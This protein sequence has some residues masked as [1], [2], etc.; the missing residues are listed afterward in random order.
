MS[1]SPA[2]AAALPPAA[3]RFA[4]FELKPGERQLVAD[5][6][7]V[8]LG[9]RAFDML[10]ALLER[11]QRVV[12]K[13]EL[14]DVVW[15][16][17]VVEENN[18]QVQVLALRKLLGPAA[19]ATVP[20][21]GYRLTL[22]VEVV[23]AA[24]RASPA[25][26]PPLPSPQRTNL[27]A[28]LPPMVG[29]AADLAALRGL[30]R[31]HTLV[32]IVGAGGIGKTRLAQALVAEIAGDF[33][34]GAWLVE[35]ASLADPAL[36]ASAVA[37]VA[38]ITLSAER[39]A[40]EAVVSVLRSQRMLLALDNCEHLLDGVVDLVD[41][42]RRA[43][44]DVRLLVTSQE[45]LKVVDEQVYRLV[46]L[47]VPPAQ[48][49]DAGDYSAVQLF[50]AA[51]K[52]AEPRF[53]LTRRNVGAVAD[54][55][56]HLDG[57]PLALQL[58]AARVPLLGIEGLRARLDERFHV[59]TGGA[60]TVLRR[61]QTLRGALEWSHGLLTA[62]EQAVFRR[63]GVFAGGF[64]LE[65]A[66]EVAAD[67]TV[68]HWQVLEH[69]GALVDK[70]L[71][72]AEGEDLPRYRLLETTRAFALERLGEAGETDEHLRRHAV[73]TRDLV[74]ALAKD[75]WRTTPAAFAA[76]VAEI[77]NVR[78]AV[79][80]AVAAP[81]ERLLAIELNVEAFRVWY[82]SALLAEGLAHC[83]AAR[84]LLDA[85][86]PPLVAAKF[87]LAYA[88]SGQ[89]SPRADCF[90]A[91]QRAARMFGDLGEASLAYDAY[92]TVAAIGARRGAVAE[93]DAAL[94]AA[95][96][97]E[98]PG[99]PSRQR[100][101]V[102]FGRYLWCQMGGRYAQALEYARQQQQLYREDGSVV[103]E[104]FA[105]GN[106]GF[107]LLALGRPE[108]A[109][110]EVRPAFA[111]LEAL[112][113]GAGAGHVIGA[114]AIALAMLGRHDEARARARIAYARLQHE[115]DTLWLLEP[116]ASSAA[117]LGRPADAARIAGFVDARY[118]TTGEVRRAPAR[119]RRAELDALLDAGLA[120][121]ERRELLA[122]GAV[123]SDDE[124]FA[125]ALGNRS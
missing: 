50:V 2:P 48:A 44:P 39:P 52:A 79:A 59:L 90:E 8:K 64:T 82:A 54:V 3:W 73:T 67:A 105:I 28:R 16:K 71:V 74:R 43:A 41:A 36:V 111:R 70:S 99:W 24:A 12:S 45:P 107:A 60:R 88:K 14:M 58:A 86:I 10:V 106:L 95:E 114:E 81:E 51:A 122:A 78:A 29:R 100:A 18:L 17:L 98:D 121:D 103:G 62:E 32:S 27:T 69:L 40:V 38:G 20:G 91:A 89:Y 63:L 57:I 19:I 72:V 102:R 93:T 123:M 115:G 31:E 110:A 47:A 94:A 119:E 1:E 37:R 35:L 84:P 53:A 80:W 49:E 87:W 124:A 30:L 9:G 61:H 26:P 85:A 7:P 97:I 113:A 108:A 56:R 65:A 11:H 21:R 34:D 116:L 101:A 118:A 25:A 22:A 83:L 120:D 15:P 46:T 92:A 96:R 13:R 23:G 6:V 75:P 33:P 66:Q 68:S 109:L 112:N 104:Q 125:L 4:R 77:D 55:C 42:L 117:A 5:G 76:L